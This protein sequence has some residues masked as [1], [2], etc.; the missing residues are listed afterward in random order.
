MEK[1]DKKMKKT[2]KRTKK[3]EQDDQ[4][5][6]RDMVDSLGQLKARIANLIKMQSS[7]EQNLMKYAEQSD[8][9][10]LEGRMFRVTVTT[11]DVKRV[12]YAGLVKRLE[13]SHQLMTAYTTTKSRTTIRVVARTGKD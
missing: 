3:Q 11:S 1:K 8:V 12:N 6:I 4:E 9:S 7:T 13:P 5:Q 10:I 2:P